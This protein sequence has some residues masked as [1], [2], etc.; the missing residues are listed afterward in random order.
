M[1][2]HRTVLAEEMAQQLL[3]PSYL[4]TSL[5]SGLFLSGPRRVGKTT[6]LASDLIPALENRGAIVIYVDLWSQPQTNP[7]D[8][9]H[10]AIRK[11]LIELQTPGSRILKKLKRVSSLSVGGAGLKF[12]FQLADVG[13]DGG[14]SLA[15][16]FT[17]LV[18]QANTDVVLIIDEVQHA[19]G[20]LEGDHL[21]H[22]LK[23]TR[24]A[25]NTR[26]GTPGYFLFVG[27]GSHRARVQELAVKGNQAFNGAVTHEFPV[28]G[29][30]FVEY[31]L[32]QVRSTLGAKTP[33]LPV[34]E[35]AFK[36]MGSRPEELLKALNVCRQLPQ[37]ALADE[38]LPTI[39]QAFGAA[40]A[41]V[42]IQKIEALGP[43][44]EAVFSRI[45]NIGGNVK[46]SF[47]GPTLREFSAQLGREVTSGDVQGVIHLMTSANLLMRVGHG[48]YGV[49]DSFV[50]QAWVTR[51]QAEDILR[52]DTP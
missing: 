21:L 23:A 33:S 34:A 51:L 5:R 50:E 7:A 14:V 8:L 35:A 30:D 17:E 13:K 26:N 38:H 6:F 36:Q 47:T 46:G 22:A 15:Q 52:T 19:M 1:T 18:D 43:L 41:D 4:D 42:E 29:Q 24:D 10:D 44:A 37:G 32:Q 27:T 31:I 39:A 11:S 48:V 3:N 28:L 9:V 16:A 20:T 25:V 2:F 45:C 49:T 12:S 40:A